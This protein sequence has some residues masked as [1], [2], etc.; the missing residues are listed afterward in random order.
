MK[1]EEK[2][3]RKTF[4]VRED[5]LN[6]LGE[7]AEFRGLSLYSLINQVFTLTIKAEEL[8]VNLENTVDEHGVL[9]RAV[10]SGFILVPEG[11]WREIVDEVYH[12]DGEWALKR[13]F[14][15]GQ[16]LAKRYI[17]R[18]IEDPLEAFRVNLE[19]FLWNVSEFSIKRDETSVSVRL[20]SSRL[21]EP[22]AMLFSSLF[23]GALQ[24]FGYKVVS[25][26]VSAGAVWLRSEKGD[27]T[28]IE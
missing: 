19:R 11:L 25:R 7:I 26:D 20:I 3:R 28:E 27:R 6:Q 4:A 8:K 24:A 16:W 5:L 21:S 1:R 23:E 10:D 9:E 15:A 14:E 22:H 12:K 13:G 2:V 18:G 17:S